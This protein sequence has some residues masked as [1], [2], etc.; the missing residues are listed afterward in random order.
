MLVSCCQPTGKYGR[1]VAFKILKTDTP[2]S[3]QLIH[4]D[5][6]YAFMKDLAIDGVH[7]T[8]AQAKPEDKRALAMGYI[9]WAASDTGIWRQRQSLIDSVQVAA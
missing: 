8:I 3:Q 2:T 1:P 5:N 4:F 6:E 9:F 7:R